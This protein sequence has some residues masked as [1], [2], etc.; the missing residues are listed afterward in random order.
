MTRELQRHADRWRSIVGLSDEQ[1][2]RQIRE[3]RIDI[4]VD[5][6]LHMA[7]NRLLVFARKPA[8]VQV[9]VCRLSRQHRADDNRLPP[10]RSVPGSAGHG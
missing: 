2:A 10:E 4:L 3:D 9:D 8:P 6:T 1:A 5:L 7:D